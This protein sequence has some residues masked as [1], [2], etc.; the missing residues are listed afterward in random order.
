MWTRR[1]KAS[2]RRRAAGSA[3]GAATPAVVTA[4]LTERAG[5]VGR[6]REARRQLQQHLPGVTLSPTHDGRTDFLLE[7]KLS[8][9]SRSCQP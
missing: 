9:C 3:A 7:T 5:F 2:C 4:R 8:S 1:W 6:E